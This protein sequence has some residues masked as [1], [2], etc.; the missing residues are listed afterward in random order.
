MQHNFGSHIDDCANYA[1]QDG[2]AELSGHRQT[3]KMIGRKQPVPSGD[4]RELWSYS[5]NSSRR[6]DLHR[7]SLPTGLARLPG[8]AKIL[9]RLAHSRDSTFLGD[10]SQCFHHA[11]MSVRMLVC[12]QVRWL[13]PSGTNSLNLRAQLTFD[14]LSAND[15]GANLCDKKWQ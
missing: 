2:R 3:Q 11:R 5:T 7:D 15:S 1:P 14:L 8:V 4:C 6:Q 10:F 13:D 9:D 12:V